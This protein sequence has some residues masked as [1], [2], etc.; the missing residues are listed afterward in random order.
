MAMKAAT[1]LEI[2][3][4]YANEVKRKPILITT[5]R[6]L[7]YVEPDIC[8]AVIAIIRVLN[9]QQL[10][11]LKRQSF[12]T[13]GKTFYLCIRLVLRRASTIPPESSLNQVCIAAMFKVF[14][15]GWRSCAQS[16]FNT[17]PHV[18]TWGILCSLA[19]ILKLEYVTSILT[20][21][22][23]FKHTKFHSWNMN[24]L[25]RLS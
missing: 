18:F 12:I 23:T 1:R 21:H 24:D 10:S 2:V 8:F 20:S 13:L 9:R 6:V 19:I 14:K 15:C 25:Y 4:K 17:C 3:P 16:R 5:L 7:P 11:F 22:Q